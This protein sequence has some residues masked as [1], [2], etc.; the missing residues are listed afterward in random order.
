MIQGV[1][2]AGGV[3]EHRTHPDREVVV[4]HSADFSPQ[5]VGDVVWRP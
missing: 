1:R 3:T 5:S 4:T 2:F